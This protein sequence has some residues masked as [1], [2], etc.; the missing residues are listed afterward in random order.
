MDKI[1]SIK[2]QRHEKW[3]EMYESYLSSG[4]NVIEWCI[5]D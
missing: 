3:Q 4:K 2:N 1:E 5:P